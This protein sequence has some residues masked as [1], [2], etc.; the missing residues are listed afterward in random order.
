[1]KVQEAWDAGYTGKNV[2]VTI[3][4]DGLEID[5]SDLI[6]NY[7]QEASTDLNDRDSNPYPR[8]TPD[9]FNSHGTRCAGVIAMM[10]NKSICVWGIAY[11]SRIGG[12]RILY[13]RVTDA[14]EASA[15]SFRSQYVDVYSSSWGPNADGK[16]VEGPGRLAT[17]ALH[18]SASKGRS[19]KRSIYVLAAGNGGDFDNCNYDGSQTNIYTV[20]ITSATEKG[21]KPFYT[22]S[23]ASALATT[24][25]SGDAGERQIC[26]T[27]EHQKCTKHHTGT[28]A[29]APL[30]AGIIALALEANPDLTWRDVQHIIVRTS[31]R[32]N[33]Q[34][35]DIG[36]TTNAA[37][38][39]VSHLYGFG[40]MDAEHMVRIAK[41]WIT[42]PDQ[43]ICEYQNNRTWVIPGAN[44]IILSQQVDGCV[45]GDQFS[46]NYLEHVQIVV[47]TKL[48]KRG[49]LSLVLISPSSTRSVIVSTRELD[50]S[51]SGLD[52]WPFMTTHFWGEKSQGMWSLEI[53]NKGNVSGNL[54][55][56]DLVLYGTETQVNSEP[57]RLGNYSDLYGEYILN[58][59][60]SLHY[61]SVNRISEID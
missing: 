23:C 1:M 46:V 25:S 56:W 22:E 9:D 20:S 58:N 55:G 14:L 13:G 54:L 38:Y 7:D 24:Y 51:K 15:L 4:D 3:A 19:E 17:L 10:T 41:K 28:S 11:N 42:S 2:V 49:D 30:A 37:G 33:L 45:S 29:S 44:K 52:K 48:S 18:D 34:D 21:T 47:S 53:E 16:T 40:L 57:V 32:Y 31:K 50:T 8:S 61:N 12:I 35:N 36:W 43:R 26:S 6:G 27:D 5:H 39:E 60:S 59:V